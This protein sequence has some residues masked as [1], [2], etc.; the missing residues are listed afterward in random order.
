MRDPVDRFFSMV[1]F[2][3]EKRSKTDDE[4]RLARAVVNRPASTTPEQALRMLHLFDERYPTW[5]RGLHHRFGELMYPVRLA[6]YGTTFRQIGE[7]NNTTPQDWDARFAAEHPGLVVGLTNAMA[8]SLALFA[9][10]LGWDHDPDVLCL[11]VPNMRQRR[12]PKR[13]L[14][15]PSVRAVIYDSLRDEFDVYQ[16]A[17]RLHEAQVA[18]Y[19]LRIADLLAGAGNRTQRCRDRRAAAL[20]Q[21]VALTT[22]VLQDIM[23]P[24]K[25][26][27]RL[28]ELMS[29]VNGTDRANASTTSSSAPR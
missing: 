10:A 3:F 13:S 6:E 1:N 24:Q 11:P 8:T 2:F 9:V 18:K 27:V 22:A 16:A 4:R 29:I 17:K 23:F 7:A 20:S 14:Y 25:Q 12:K 19:R 5:G 26:I 15:R 28:C 21:D